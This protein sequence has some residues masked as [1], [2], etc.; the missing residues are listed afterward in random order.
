[1][2]IK[3]NLF[4]SSDFRKITQTKRRFSV[5]EYERDISVS[6]DKAQTAYFASEMNVRKKQL[7]IQ[8]ENDE[9]VYVQAGEMQLI[10]GDIEASSDVNSSVQLTSHSVFSLNS[11]FSESSRFF[12]SSV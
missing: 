5:L 10:I 12:K 11:S 2:D 4:E 1:M 9:G 6:P 7:V 3:T 8:V